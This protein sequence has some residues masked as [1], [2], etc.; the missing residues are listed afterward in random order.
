RQVHLRSVNGKWI[1]PS[2]AF[3]AKHTWSDTHRSPLLFKHAGSS[4]C[5]WW[6]GCVSWARLRKVLRNLSHQ[7][8]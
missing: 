6:A 5:W 2:P 7:L 1:F 8:C 4:W 3:C